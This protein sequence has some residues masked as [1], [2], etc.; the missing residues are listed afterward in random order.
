MKVIKTNHPKTLFKNN[1]KI[2]IL[3]FYLLTIFLSFYSFK[4]QFGTLPLDNHAWRNTQ[5]L[6]ARMIFST[7]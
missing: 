4:D 2:I 7:P 6:V 5:T 1:S 3:I